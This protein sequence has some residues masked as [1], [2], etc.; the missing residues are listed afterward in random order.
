MIQLLDNVVL[1]CSVKIKTSF[2]RAR[3]QAWA[4]FYRRALLTHNVRK[5]APIALGAVAFW[6]EHDTCYMYSKPNMAISSRD[7][8]IL[9]IDFV[10]LTAS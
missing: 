2:W 1:Y 5:A 9:K 4:N 7:A 3:S 10:K 8:C 6:Q